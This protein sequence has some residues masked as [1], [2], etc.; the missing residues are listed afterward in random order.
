MTTPRF[1]IVF[2]CNDRSSVLTLDHYSFSPKKYL[3]LAHVPLTDTFICSIHLPRTCMGPWS[4]DDTVIE[5][6]VILVLFCFS[7]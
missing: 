3:C 4:P 2:S 5:S 7:L 6:C 1:L